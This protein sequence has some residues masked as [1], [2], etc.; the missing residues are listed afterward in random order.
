LP[1]S[2]SIKDLALVLARL[3]D[4]HEGSDIEIQR[5]KSNKNRILV[6]KHDD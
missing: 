6:I 1:E 3:L 2:F 4:L 5:D